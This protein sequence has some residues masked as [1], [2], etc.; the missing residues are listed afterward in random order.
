MWQRTIRNTILTVLVCFF[1][2]ASTGNAKTIYVDSDAAGANDG[3]SW[4][5]AYNYLQDALTDANASEKPVEIRVAQAIYRPDEDT[6][7]PDGTGDREATFQLINGVALKGGY[8]GF[9]SPDPNARDITKYETILSGDLNGDDGPNFANNDENCYHVVTGSG[10]NETAVIDGFTITAG[11]AE[12]DFEWHD[13]HLNGAGMINEEG[14]PTVTGCKFLHNHVQA[15]GGGMWNYGSDPALTNCVFFGNQA[16]GGGGG[17]CNREYS[18][19]TITNCLLWGNTTDGWGGGIENFT[20]CNAV[21]INCTITNNTS[22]LS[23]GGGMHNDSSNPKLT[24]CIVYGNKSSWGSAEI[25][26]QIA[27]WLG[28]I[29]NSCIGGWTSDLEGTG[30][31]G[32]DPLF[33]DSD[34]ADNII[35][36][37][38]DNFHLLPGSP[39][40]DA[41]ENSVVPPS[42]TLDLDGKARIANET[43]DM[44]VFE[45]PA[46]GFLLSTESIT[47]GE[48]Q[49]DTFTVALA[50]DPLGSVEIAIA[51]GSGDGDITVASAPVLTLDSDDYHIPWVVTL[52]AAQ[53]ADYFNGTALIE[54]SSPGLPTAGVTVSE[55][56][57][58]APAVLYVD[59][60]APGGGEGTSWAD[61]FDD[62]HDALDI[63]NAV[64][65]VKEIHVAQGTYRPAGPGGDRSISFELVNRVS[66]TGG[67]AGLGESDPDARDVGAYETVLSGDLNGDDIEVSEPC[68]LFN[69]PTRAENSWHVLTAPK[70]VNETTILDG[71]TI[72]A[73]NA[74]GG[75]YPP[76]ERNGGG[77]DIYE[78]SNPTV[79]NCVFIGNSADNDGGGVNGDALTNCK[80]IGNAAQ[81]GGGAFSRVTLPGVRLTDCEFIG[82]FAEDGGGLVCH[83]EVVDCTFIGNSARVWGGGVSG[84]AALTN[85]TFTANS[86]GEAGGALLGCGTLT[87]CI[88]S[89]NSAGEIGG[90]MYS[91]CYLCDGKVINCT[92]TGNRAGQLGGAMFL[93]DESYRKLS[94]SI[95][96]DNSAPE[97]PQIAIEA[98]YYDGLSVGYCN[99]QGGKAGIYGYDSKVKWGK[100]NIDIDP[101]FADPN[102]GDYHLQSE[103]GRWDPNSQSWV[104]DDVTSPCIDAGDP[105]SPIGPEPFPN[106]GI[107]NMGAY[108]GTAE[109]S[110][111]YFGTPPCETIVAGDINGDCIVDFRDLCIMALHW[112]EDHNL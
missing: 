95:L 102:G 88:F 3:S 80:F 111:S 14:H 16:E 66:V 92:F 65:Q 25:Y 90:A 4:E 48:G 56:D 5:N 109:A 103:A 85:C 94:N 49:T 27:D 86:A 77:I 71:F 33:V 37:E 57:D 93:G 76:Y 12:G 52:A 6:L 7:H 70:G 53:D 73:G 98:A 10:T 101:I 15:Y 82:N 24:N 41:G 38:D 30:N 19:P 44:G 96:W 2:M 104:I 40:L 99:V 29:N 43:V 55:W 17:I 46:Q 18:S 31:H 51:V 58:E 50:M 45:G 11:N 112:C 9:G 97:G 54:I 110:K 21:L 34:G 74:T 42:L 35:G 23:S 59:Q 83:G 68:D 72:T 61:A 22:G 1:A 105:M 108:G 36:T 84:N 87:N 32:E 20:G 78:D 63:A 8:A 81:Y 47:I 79:R 26:S 100:G 69:E 67:Y 13:P 60:D 106:G 107:V 64:V 91:Y 89:A 28:L 75:D 39:C 62:L